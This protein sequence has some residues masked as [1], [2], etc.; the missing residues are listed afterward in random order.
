M[1]KKRGDK[2]TAGAGKTEKAMYE[3]QMKLVR[4]KNYGRLGENAP[5]KSNLWPWEGPNGG[6][7]LGVPTINKISWDNNEGKNGLE[8]A[9][10]R[11]CKP[12]TA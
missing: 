5:K 7:P 10:G 8:T 4:N 1:K 2:N 11:T 12:K 6:G 9:R 3:N